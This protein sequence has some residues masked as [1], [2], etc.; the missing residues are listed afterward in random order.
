MLRLAIADSDRTGPVD[1]VVITGPVDADR[2]LLS[3][4]CK[5]WTSRSCVVTDEQL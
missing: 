1:A 5:L 3:S 4:A 2:V